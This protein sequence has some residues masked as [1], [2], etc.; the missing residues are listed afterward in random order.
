MPSGSFAQDLQALAPDF[1]PGNRTDS[2]DVSFRPRDVGD[3]TDR[4]RITHGADNGDRVYRSFETQ[5][6][7]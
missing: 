1:G 2:R 7:S 5:N 4:N 6:E 3:N